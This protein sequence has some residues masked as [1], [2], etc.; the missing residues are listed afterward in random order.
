[1]PIPRSMALLL[2]GTLVLLVGGI[3]FALVAVRQ[4]ETT[5]PAGSPEAA[6]ATYLR[7]LQNGQID[8][9][10]AMTALPSPSLTRAYFHEQ[11]DRWS[12][13]PHRVTLLRSNT[14][15]NQASVVVDI[16]TFSPDIFGGGDRSSQQTF[17]LVRQ[18][19]AW[20][21]TWPDYLYP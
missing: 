20:R 8:D 10:Y 4:P 7:L 3:V 17:M 13:T 14:T 18:D 16:S 6:V 5:F 19:G 15:G 1:M 11:F 21:I 12:Q 2:G 9:A